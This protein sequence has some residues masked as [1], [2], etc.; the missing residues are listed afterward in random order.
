[1]CLGFQTRRDS[2]QPVGMEVE[3]WV[4]GERGFELRFG[5]KQSLGFGGGWQDI[6]SGRAEGSK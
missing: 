6:A 2:F 3:W 5:I 4:L 1:M